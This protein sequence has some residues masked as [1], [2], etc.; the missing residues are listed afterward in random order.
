MSSVQITD[1]FQVFST[2]FWLLVCIMVMHFIRSKHEGKD[3]YQYFLPQFYAK[4]F[5][6]LVFSLVYLLYY[7]GGDT[8][9]YW[10]GAACLNK[11]FYYSPTDY[12]TEMF[13]TPSIPEIRARFNFFTGI[14]PGWIY[15]EPESF[16][17]SKITSL[18]TFLTF[19]N[20]LATTF[21]IAT[22]VSLINWHF[23]CSVR[24]LELHKE[25]ILAICILFTP[26]VL[27]WC[28]G[29]SK[30]TYVLAALFL[31]VSFLIRFFILNQR[32]TKMIIGLLVASY[33][34]LTI[35]SFIFAALIPGILVAYNTRI[36]PERIDSS[37]QR[38]T[39]KFFIFSICLGVILFATFFS[40]SGFGLAGVVEEIL[41]IQQDFANNATYGDK[42]YVID[43]GNGSYGAILS[44]APVALIAAFYRPF[45]WEALSP[46]L[47][48]NGIENLILFYLTGFLIYKNF[49]RKMRFI[50]Q[51]E[52]LLFSAI[53]ILIMG[54]SIGFT[55]G[56]FGVLVRLKSIILPFFLILLTVGSERRNLATNN[57]SSKSETPSGL[58]PIT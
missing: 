37:V 32:N 25:R 33:L 3:H 10:D 11:L 9:A 42:R 1:V 4:I 48:F 17:I 29:I 41:I 23:F 36:T 53:F 35:R 5:S 49:K 57:K 31:L 43:I 22:I 44:S 8:I 2:V 55:S 16:F 6:A 14:P 28:S 40:S 38:F 24:L 20:Y 7:E 30:D 13:T 15:R 56:L 27:F 18:F 12:L 51:N 21:I 19:K 46:L 54:F 34:I 50:Y 26:S 52:F 47:I 39:I 45:P 58:K